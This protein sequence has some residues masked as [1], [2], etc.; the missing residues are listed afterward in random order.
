VAK[1]GGRRCVFYIAN[2]IIKL[3]KEYTAS[4]NKPNDLTYEKLALLLFITNGY[5][6]S[7]HG[8]PLVAQ[9]FRSSKK[10]P[11]VGQLWALLADHKGAVESIDCIA[12]E[13]YSL[14][15]SEKEHIREVFMAYYKHNAAAL[16][17]MV[18]RPGTPW[19]ETEQIFYKKIM[20]SSEWS[21]AKHIFGLLDFIWWDAIPNERIKHYYDSL[22]NSINH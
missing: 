12:E 20:K 17:A 3:A 13:K 15:N 1:I 22:A 4:K 10:G 8:V 21:Q 5:F 19:H 2:E 11:H 7:F 6:L 18:R 14:L 9:E 16:G